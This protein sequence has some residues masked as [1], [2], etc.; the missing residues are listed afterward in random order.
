MFTPV[1]DTPPSNTNTADAIH[2]RAD[3]PG[4]R[5]AVAIRGRVDRERIDHDVRPVDNMTRGI[6][7]R[8]QIL[9]VIVDAAAID[10]DMDTGAAVFI[11][12]AFNIANKSE[13]P[14][15]GVKWIG[16]SCPVSPKF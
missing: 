11:P 6:V 2:C 4:A 15:A 8:R 12:D 1:S 5:R 16:W 7:I 14:L 13:M 9:M 3:K 10:A